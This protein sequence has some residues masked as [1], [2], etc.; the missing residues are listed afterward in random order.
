MPGIDVYYRSNE[1]YRYDWEPFRRLL[2]EGA[3]R[4]FSVPERRLQAGSFS[5]VFH[6]VN[7]PSRLTHTVIVRLQLHAYPARLESADTDA[8]ELAE[9]LAQLLERDRGSGL[10]VGVSLL[11]AEIGWSDAVS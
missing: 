11:L 2:S 9:L 7:S 8:S 10:T 3:A 1:F 4:L 6:A 5:T